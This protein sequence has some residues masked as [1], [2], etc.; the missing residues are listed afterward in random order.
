[1]RGRLTAYLCLNRRK[2]AANNSRRNPDANRRAKTNNARSN[3]GKSSNART[4]TG[5]SATIE[6]I[7]SVPSAYLSLRFFNALTSPSDSTRLR[8]LRNSDSVISA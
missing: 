6:T 8:Y 3:S 5:A 2:T 1:M 7:H 4:M